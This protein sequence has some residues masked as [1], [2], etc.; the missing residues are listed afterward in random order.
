MI[1]QPDAMRLLPSVLPFDLLADRRRFFGLLDGE[2]KQDSAKK[3]A[4]AME[5]RDLP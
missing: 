2:G 4:T 5:A 3:F 1:H